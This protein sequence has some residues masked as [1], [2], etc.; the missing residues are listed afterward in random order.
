M[1]LENSNRQSI[2]GRYG[3]RA[4]CWPS[5]DYA[6][7][8]FSRSTSSSLNWNNIGI[9]CQ[10]AANV[11]RD[12]FNI[13]DTIDVFS[14]HGI[15]GIFGTLMIAIFGCASF[16]DQFSGLIN[17]GIFTIIITYILIKIVSLITALRVYEETETKGL[18][19][20]VHSE[21][22]YDVNS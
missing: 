18:D 20:S 8:C 17:L 4:T 16:V 9:L 11:V 12:V 22:A 7:S 14:V 1:A 15:V 21:R 10:E 3:R 19:L 5:F 2:F 6:S 13:D